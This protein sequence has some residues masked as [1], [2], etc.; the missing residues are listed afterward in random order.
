[1][2]QVRWL[3]LNPNLLLKL[4]TCTKHL[5]GTIH[6]LRSVKLNRA[7]TVFYKVDQLQTSQERINNL[8]VWTQVDCNV[9][10]L[11]IYY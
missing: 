9:I 6:S 11:A 2:D 10:K 1:M 5:V 8:H 7:A 4:H 3:T